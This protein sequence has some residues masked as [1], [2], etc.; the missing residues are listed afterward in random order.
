MRRCR[1]RFLLKHTQRTQQHNHNEPNNMQHQRPPI[2]T[3]KNNNR[4]KGLE[5]LGVCENDVRIAE[6][7]LNQIQSC[8]SSESSSKAE[9]ILGYTSSRL[10]RE[11]ALKLLGASEYEVELENCKNLGSL[12]Q[13]GRRRSFNPPSDLDSL[14]LYH[15]RRR[16]T[17]YCPRPRLTLGLKRNT[18]A[19]VTSTTTNEGFRRKS[20]VFGSSL[21]SQVNISNRF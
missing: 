17:E 1:A 15:R 7:L 11:K 16:S 20:R 13:S 10:C 2:R 6:R 8:S 5:K 18:I 19:S 9:R 21:Q 4:S 3:T 12:G 14:H